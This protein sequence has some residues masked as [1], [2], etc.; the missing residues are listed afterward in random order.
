[1]RRSILILA[2]VIAWATPGLAQTPEDVVRW[3]YAS[4]VSDRPWNQQGVSF[5][6]A[7]SQRGHFFT[8][9]LVTLFEADDSYGDDMAQQCLPFDFA[10]PGNDF[11]AAEIVR[12]L[13]LNTR[14]IPGQISVT[15]SFTTFGQ[16]AQVV[17]DFAQVDGVW[18]IDDVAGAGFRLSEIDCQPK[19]SAALAGSEPAN[20]YCYARGD[21][22]LKVELLPANRARIEI[23]SWQ[24]GGHSCGGRMEGHQVVDGWH[25]PGEQGCFLRLRLGDEGSLNIIDPD[26]ACKR[27]MCGQR[28]VL[29]GMQF[30]RDSQVACAGWDRLPD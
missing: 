7:P 3:I 24:G 15:A 23:S 13:Q 16:P 2:L 21:D 18:K 30:P 20:S 6:R 4:L 28:A 10:I 27:T 29:D 22:A 9:R 5:L 19:G 1:M 11:D 26:W 25:F 12:T 8:P 17:Y 14:T